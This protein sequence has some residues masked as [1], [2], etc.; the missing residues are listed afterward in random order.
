MNPDLE[1]LNALILS[2][3]IGECQL[4]ALIKILMKLF[5]PND[6]H[7][8]LLNK[9]V[10]YESACDGIFSLLGS[11]YPSA[12]IDIFPDCK[13]LPW[14]HYKGLPIRI[15]QDPYGWCFYIAVPRRHVLFGEH[16]TKL[17]SNA[18]YSN[19]MSGNQLWWE[20]GWD[21]KNPCWFNPIQLLS[22]IKRG[23]PNAFMDAE[24]LSSK[25]FMN[26]IQNALDMLLSIHKIKT[27]VEFALRP[28]ISWSNPRHRK[29]KAERFEKAKRTASRGLQ[30]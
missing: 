22:D 3:L 7:E 10:D 11:Y 23:R 14:N 2:F 12:G 19:F 6:H 15:S 26:A 29:I 8:A 28:C 25:Y 18:T 17:P 27:G 1:L 24:V 9:T 21:F 5:I 20:F 4:Y 13:D 30:F 16:Y